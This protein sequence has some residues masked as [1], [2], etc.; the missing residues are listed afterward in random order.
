MAPFLKEGDAPMATEA[1]LIVERATLRWLAQQHPDWTQPEL[2]RS[3]RK[4]VDWIKKWLKRFRQADPNEVTV[5]PS[6]SRAR[7]TPPASLAQQPVLVQRI[8][9]I[10][11]TPPENLQRPPGHETILSSLHR[12]SCLP[13]AGV[14]LPRATFADL[15]NAAAVWRSCARPRAQAQATGHTSAGGR[16]ATRSQGDRECAT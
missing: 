3:L 16:G 5:L 9:E 13:A 15:E 7:K 4:S 8:V 2:A 14:R 1:Q 6:R 11:Q 12:D 10:R